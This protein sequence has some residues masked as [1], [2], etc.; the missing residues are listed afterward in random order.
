MFGVYFVLIGLAFSLQGQLNTDQ[1]WGY[2]KDLQDPDYETHIALIHS[3]FSTNTFPS[4][5]RA[6]PQ[7]FVV[8]LIHSIY[9][10]KSHF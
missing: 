1:L 2:F 6:H 8:P 5:E 10:T 3:R 4:W 7:R 9:Y